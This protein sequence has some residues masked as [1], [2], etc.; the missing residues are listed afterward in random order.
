METRGVISKGMSALQLIKVT[1]DHGHVERKE[2]KSTRCASSQGDIRWSPKAR[3]LYSRR[4]LLYC[5]GETEWDV[6]HAVSRR[7]WSLRVCG[8][9]AMCLEDGVTGDEKE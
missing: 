8:P 5:Q 7:A 3:S 9:P 6:R 1:S 2:G 4:S